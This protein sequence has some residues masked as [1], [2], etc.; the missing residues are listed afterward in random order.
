MELL[1]TPFGSFPVYLNRLFESQEITFHV[2]FVDK[3]NKLHVVLMQCTAEKSIIMN[4]ESLPEWIVALQDQLDVMIRT[5]L[6]KEQ[7]LISIAG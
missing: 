6:S 1:Q 5:E 4:R 3:N 2:S 7:P